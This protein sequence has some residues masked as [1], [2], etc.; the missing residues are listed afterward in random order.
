MSDDNVEKETEEN[1]TKG[2]KKLWSKVR[3]KSKFQD[4][5]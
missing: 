2:V 3:K 4:E 1:S 5:R